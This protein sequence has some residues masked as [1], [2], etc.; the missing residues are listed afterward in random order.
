MAFEG[1]H[2]WIY[3][4]ENGRPMTEYHPTPHINVESA[5]KLITALHEFVT[6]AENAELTEPA[7]Y[8]EE[9]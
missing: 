6:M 8:S 2:A 9:D 3:Y 4:K 1:A 7:I 5:K